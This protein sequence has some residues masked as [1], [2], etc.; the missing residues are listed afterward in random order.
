MERKKITT[1]IITFA[2]LLQMLASVVFGQNITT[3]Q[4]ASNSLKGKES[5]FSSKY[6]ED[7]AQLVKEGKLNLADN[8][9]QETK[10]AETTLA[11][12]GHKGVIITDFYNVKSALV[13][14]N[15]AARLDSENALQN[16]RGKRIV[17]LNLGVLIADSPNAQQV[18]MRLR[19]ILKQIETVKENVILY[20]EDI[21]A[22]SKTNPVFGAEIARTLRQSIAD[23]KSAGYQHHKC[24]RL[25]HRNSI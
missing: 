24:R 22:F 18:S 15:L 4:L 23:G 17:R 13:I 21:S 8:L 5:K 19:T 9:E 14:K 1:I 20:V 6:I 25:Q 2:L 11:A 3:N 16:L 10:K 12:A 7:V